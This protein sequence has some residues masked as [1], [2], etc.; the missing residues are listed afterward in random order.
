MAGDSVEP[1]PSENES[2]IEVRE[3]RN[4]KAA[5]LV[6]CR[7]RSEKEEEE[8][9]KGEGG[10]VWLIAVSWEGGFNLLITLMVSLGKGRKEG[11]FPAPCRGLRE[12]GGHGICFD[13]RT[14]RSEEK[15]KE[16]IGSECSQLKEGGGGGAKCFHLGDSIY[17]VNWQG[18]GEEGR[19]RGGKRAAFAVL[20]FRGNEGRG[21]GE[22]G[23]TSIGRRPE[24]KRDMRERG[25]VILA[26]SGEAEQRGETSA[27]V[28][29]RKR[30]RGGKRGGGTVHWK[31]GEKGKERGGE[32]KGVDHSTYR[33]REGET[34][35]PIFS[36]PNRKKRGEGRG[37][38]K[39]GVRIPC[40]IR[41]QMVRGKGEMTST[42]HLYK[43]ATQKGKKEE[44][45]KA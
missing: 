30:R 37:K 42:L 34:S 2:G 18:K 20:L 33:S 24:G 38:R 11:K 23:L 27:P 22:A 40:N 45:G 41:N 10:E 36:W 6:L 19:E 13:R 12:G 15:G 7:R 17:G 35:L 5:M 16:G 44:G 21:K 39:G 14:G 32:E 29:C 1:L 9:G 8:K 26:L 28:G 43:R 4:R 25:E 31:K 3:R